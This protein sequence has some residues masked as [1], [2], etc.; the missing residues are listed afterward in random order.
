MR[1]R[2]EPIYIR[3]IRLLAQH[4]GFTVGR[5][6]CSVQAWRCLPSRHY[7]GGLAPSGG[8]GLTRRRGRSS[9]APTSPASRPARST[10]NVKPGPTLAGAGWPRAD[11]LADLHG[12]S[13]GAK[14]AAKLGLPP[15]PQI[16]PIIDPQ[17]HT[18]AVQH[19]TQH[20][21]QPLTDRTEDWSDRGR[22]LQCDVGQLRAARP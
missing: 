4:G 22:S 6:R 12:A 20:H 3:L 1:E 5:L 16:D 10:T 14:V 18:P 2:S 11:L 19:R 15:I 17:P 8:A 9:C 13:F 21:I 7:R